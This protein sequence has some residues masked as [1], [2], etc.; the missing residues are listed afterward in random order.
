M[1]T[2]L[3]KRVIASIQGD[4]PVTAHPYREIAA[5]LGITE[6]ALLS[7]LR[8]LCQR[9]II[10]RFGATLRHQKSG[11]QANAMVAWRVEEN[12][13]D[14]VGEK[15]AAFRQ[16]SHCYCRTPADGW[17]YNLYTMIHAGDEKTCLE[18]AR[19]MAEKVSVKT[20]V[21]LFSRKELKK[22]SMDYFSS[23]PVE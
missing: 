4:I 21:L 7:T 16:V 8:S 13:V 5:E 2:N 1:L 3:E 22:T 19:K 11:F 12:R 14:E 6:T 10:R 9:S 18:V 20:Y 17:P 15:L 23:S